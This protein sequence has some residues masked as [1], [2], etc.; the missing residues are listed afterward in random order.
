MVVTVDSWC[1][2]GLAGAG[3]GLQLDLPA[4]DGADPLSIPDSGW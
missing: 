3:V 4:R 2:V 1:R